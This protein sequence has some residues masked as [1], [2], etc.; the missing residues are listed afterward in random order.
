MDWTLAPLVALV[1][2]QPDPT[3]ADQM[4]C[5]HYTSRP[6]VEC[7]GMADRMLKRRRSD[8]SPLPACIR[9][10]EALK[11]PKVAQWRS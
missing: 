1:L 7:M 10:D 6:Y 11:L 4:A 3:A 8:A 9:L 5:V 2:C